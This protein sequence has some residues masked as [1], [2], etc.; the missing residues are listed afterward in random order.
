[1]RYSAVARDEESQKFAQEAPR[2][3]FGPW[4]TSFDVAVLGILSVLM[5]ATLGLMAFRDVTATKADPCDV[6]TISKHLHCVPPQIPGSFSKFLDANGTERE[7][8]S[9]VL[10]QREAAARER[11]G[12][13]HSR[14]HARQRSSRADEGFDDEGEWLDPEV[15]RTAPTPAGTAALRRAS[16]AVEGLNGRDQ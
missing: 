11:Q 1:M 2:H 13:H 5:V 12:I 9:E 7:H 14:G 10:K 8:S 4:A 3:W 6:L 16:E 15:F